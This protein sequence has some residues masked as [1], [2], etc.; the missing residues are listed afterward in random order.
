MRAIQECWK[1][2]EMSP[3]LIVWQLAEKNRRNLVLFVGAKDFLGASVE[4]VD[5]AAAVNYG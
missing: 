2:Q 5:V 1:T 4:V 3:F